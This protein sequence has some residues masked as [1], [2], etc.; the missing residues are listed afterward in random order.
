MQFSKRKKTATNL[1]L[2]KPI[3]EQGWAE[4]ASLRTVRGELRKADVLS[5]DTTPHQPNSPGH[6]LSQGWSRA[7]TRG[8]EGSLPTHRDSGWENC[9]L[10]PSDHARGSIGAGWHLSSGTR[11]PVTCRSH[12]RGLNTEFWLGK[13][14]TSHTA[15][16]ETCTQS[17]R[18]SRSPQGPQTEPCPAQGREVPLLGLKALRQSC[19]AGKAQSKTQTTSATHTGT[20]QL[21]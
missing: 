7:L 10:P 2:H 11:V 14:P 6:P 9:R 18:I 16:E 1:L 19:A 21:K 13:S 4:G 5:R 3:A 20:F 15:L 12:S 8:T 17:I